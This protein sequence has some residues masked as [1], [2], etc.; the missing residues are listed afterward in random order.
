[1]ARFFKFA[2]LSF[3]SHPMRGEALNVGLLIATDSGFQVRYTSRLEKLRAISAAL[4]IEAVTEDLRA[5][6]RTLSNLGAGDLHHAAFDKALSAFTPFRVSQRGEFLATDD[7]MLERQ[8]TDLM[9]RYVT[10][11]PAVERPRLKKHSRLRQT[12]KQALSLERI[13]A[14]PS[15]GLESHRVL[16]KHKLTDGFVADFVLRNGAMHVVESVDASSETISPH[17]ALVDI[18]MSAMTFEHARIV[19]SGESVKPRLIYK[20]SS[21]IEKVLSS[22]LYAAQHQGAEVIN[23]ESYDQRKKFLVTF[24]TLAHSLNEAERYPA[25][26]DASI[27]PRQRLN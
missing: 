4:E 10:P 6:P 16:F 20:A 13:L 1:M 25:L 27:L 5:L 7:Q 17:R 23:W 2:V 9:S 3:A 14:R 21:E 12:I 15:E 8:V 18:A 24:T 22:S 19:Y 11:E 26:F